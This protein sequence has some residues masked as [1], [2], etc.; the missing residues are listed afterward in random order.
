MK[1]RFMKDQSRYHR[2]AK[3]AEVLNVS[4]GGY[5]AYIKREQSARSRD[6]KEL[7]AQIRQIQKNEV[8]GSYGAPRMTAELNGRGYGVGH[9]RVAR[10]MA[11]ND[12]QAKRPKKYR[13]TTLSDHDHRASPNLV[14]R[15]FAPPAANM[16]WASDL[17]Y[18]DTAEG[19]L[20][21][22]AILDLY[23]RKV[24]GWAMSNRMGTN[25]VLQALFMAMMRTR[26]PA[27]VIFHSDRGVQYASRKF[28]RVLSRYGFRQSM[29]RKGNCWDN[30]VMESFFATLKRELIAGRKYPTRQEAIAEI[31]EYLEVF[32]NR[33]R[34][35]SYL[36]YETP[37]AYGSHAA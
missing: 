32:Y 30:A 36:S 23:N 7:V 21:L 15:D 5:Y 27:G 24:I 12:L 17:T 14:D 22:C 11:E 28:R 26:H 35:H 13:V 33:K 16:V 10:L 1:F 25:L 31:F 19:W 2:V 29:S 18:I 6:D 20:Y 37:Q 8:K 4:R 9:N 3:M 34:V